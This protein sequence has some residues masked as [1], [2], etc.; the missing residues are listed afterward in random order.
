MYIEILKMNLNQ[1]L[2]YPSCWGFSKNEELCLICMKRYKYSEIYTF[3]IFLLNKKEFQYFLFQH[4][5]IITYANTTKHTEYLNLL[6]IACELKRN[7]ICITVMENLK[8]F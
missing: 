1:F 2:P 5:N 7:Q 8:I 4:L 6:F 3:E